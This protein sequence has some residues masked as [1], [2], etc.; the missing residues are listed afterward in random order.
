MNNITNEQ[1]IPLREAIAKL[2]EF[3]EK[4]PGKS[5]PYYYRFLRYMEQ[6]IELY[7][8]TERGNPHILEDILRRDW[9]YIRKCIFEDMVYQTFEEE[10]ATTRIYSFMLTKE[11]EKFFDDF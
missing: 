11:V 7:I 5:Y 1:L 6:N 9:N 10:G 4:F 8:R 2:A 3:L